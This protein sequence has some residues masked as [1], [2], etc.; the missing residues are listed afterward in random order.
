MGS[1]TMW[2]TKPKVKNIGTLDNCTFAIY[3][4]LH[5]DVPGAIFLEYTASEFIQSVVAAILAKT[6]T[7][8]DFCSLSESV[9]ALSV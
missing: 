8:Q 3:N 5:E 4:E 7:A 6:G 2:K 1:E 9:S